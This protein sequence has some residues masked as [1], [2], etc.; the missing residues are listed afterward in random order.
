MTRRQDVAERRALLAR[1]YAVDHAESL[2]RKAA[3]PKDLLGWFLRGFRAEVPERIH[4]AGLWHDVRQRTDD[5]KYEPVGGSLIGTPAANGRFRSL[6]EGSPERETELARL[7]E[8]GVTVADTAYSMPIRAALDRLAGRGRDSEPFPMMAAALRRVAY[9][10]GEWETA[11][12]HLVAFTRTDAGELVVDDEASVSLR[13]IFLDT[14]LERLWD[15]YL[16]EPPARSI[17][18]EEVAV[19]S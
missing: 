9:F 11:L 14:A 13:R 4:A 6:T 18:R 3:K 2:R 10:N 15:R 17:R 12:G 19:A 5:E 8:S 7:T 16:D 1:P